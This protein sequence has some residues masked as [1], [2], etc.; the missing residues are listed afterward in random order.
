MLCR[1][2]LLSRDPFSVLNS[3][4]LVA[5]TVPWE[6]RNSVED[7]ELFPVIRTMVQVMQGG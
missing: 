4:F 5:E 3:W 1:A 2:R 6:I 7:I